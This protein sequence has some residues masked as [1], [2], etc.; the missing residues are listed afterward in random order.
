MARL[1]LGIVAKT[2]F[3]AEVG[4]EADEIGEAMTVMLEMFNLL[5][6][7]FAEVL[8]KLPLPMVR[9]YEA[10]RSRLDSTIY[11][12]INERRQ[13]GVDRHDRPVPA[14]GAVT[15]GGDASVEHF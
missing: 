10:M 12:I 14:N 1:T 5:M 2:L 6:Y 4:K 3:D 9:R 15:R 11:R 8:E 13:S 7:P